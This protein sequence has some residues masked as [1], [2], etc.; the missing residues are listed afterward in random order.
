MDR[1]SSQLDR[2][3][4]S[5]SDSDDSVIGFGPGE[6]RL[7]QES[8]RH[9]RIDRQLFEL[10]ELDVLYQGNHAALWTFMRPEGRPS[11]TPSMLHD[12][13]DWQRLIVEN[14]GSGQ[15]PLRYLIL[16]SRAPGVYCFGGDLE[17]F[18]RL[19]RNRD[20]D[21]LARYGYR[22]VEI[23]HRNMNALDLPMLT[24]GLVQG[25]AL[26]GGFE[27]LLSFDHII[28]ER[29]ATFG[30]PEILFG[31]FPGMGAHAILSRKLGSA[32][33]DRLIL[34]NRTYTAE[35]MYDLGVVH[36]LAEDG[37]GVAVCEDFIQKSERRHPGL[38]NARKAMRVASPIDLL[39]LKRIVDLWADAALQLTDGDLKV[40]GRLTRAQQR[41]GNKAAA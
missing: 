27:A 41:V 4:E 1:L 16:G 24:I 12:F 32:M 26:G 28:A 35:E 33:A 13:E 39:E 7:V 25:A 23:L 20:R 34:S 21:G 14:F 29:S 15:V 38:V 36:Y 40:M 18:E 22:C 30:M 5:L 11:F 19:I 2:L 8:S 37:E 3:N 9:L 17:L 31:L 6:E 10:S